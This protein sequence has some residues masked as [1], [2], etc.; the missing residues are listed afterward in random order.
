M[1]VYMYSVILYFV[2]VLGTRELRCWLVISP[3]ELALHSST[4]V[5][6]DATCY[7]NLC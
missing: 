3:V 1:V 7:F 5:Q 6:H 4:C 2:V